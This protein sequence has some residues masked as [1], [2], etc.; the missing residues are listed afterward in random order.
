[1][2]DELEKAIAEENLVVAPECTEEPQSQSGVNTFRDEDH[3]IEGIRNTNEEKLE[4][5]S[6]TASLLRNSQRNATS[7]IYPTPL[8]ARKLGNEKESDTYSQEIERDSLSFMKHRQSQGEQQDSVR[9]M[10]SCCRHLNN[11]NASQLAKA[12][13]TIEASAGRARGKRKRRA[14]QAFQ[15]QTE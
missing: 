2:I 9:R 5:V 6:N 11:S 3:P 15:Q 13:T 10:S 7:A 1:M 4:E 14:S 12:S 8:D